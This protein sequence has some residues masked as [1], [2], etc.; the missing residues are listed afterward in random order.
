MRARALHQSSR[1]LY[2]FADVNAHIR[3]SFVAHLAEHMGGL[4]YARSIDA[5]LEQAEND[6]PSMHMRLERLRGTIIGRSKRTIVNLT[7]GSKILSSVDSSV[8]RFLESLPELSTDNRFSLFV[9]WMSRVVDRCCWIIGLQAKDCH[10]KM[11]ELSS[12][13]RL[14][15]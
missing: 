1:P 4:S 7:A 15:T 9:V 5:L 6:W 12:H 2:Y 13:R 10:R 11:R 3:F 14:I 8:E